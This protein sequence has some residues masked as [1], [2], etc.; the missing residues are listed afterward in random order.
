MRRARALDCDQG[1]YGARGGGA[2]L[3]DD[4]R[5]VP[6][7]VPLGLLALE[8]LHLE[9]NVLGLHDAGLDLGE[10]RRLTRTV[11]SRAK[12]SRRKSISVKDFPILGGEFPTA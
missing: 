10:E 7:A 3:F 8:G 1:D 4:A 12:F 6:P 2:D 9:L 5:P 11:A